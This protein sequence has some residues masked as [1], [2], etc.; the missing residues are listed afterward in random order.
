M[1][2]GARKYRLLLIHREK[3]TVAFIHQLERTATTPGYAGQ[4]VI[5]NEYRQAGFLGNQ[6]VQSF[7]QCATPGQHDTG[8]HNVG[9]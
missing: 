9:T 3:I 5:S 7:E 2:V 4:R 6:A 8:F 1:T